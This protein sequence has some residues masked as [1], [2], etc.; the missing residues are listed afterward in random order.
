VQS[1]AIGSA[2]ERTWKRTVKQAAVC[3]RERTSERTWELAMKCI[4]KLGFKC[5]MQHH[6]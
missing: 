3:N 2:W 1:S 4:W 6:V 5:C